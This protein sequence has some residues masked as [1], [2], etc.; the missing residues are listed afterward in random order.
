MDCAH[1]DE[2]IKIE[3]TYWWHIA[4]QELLLKLLQRFCRP[5]ARIVEGGIGGGNTLHTLS[6]LGYQVSGLDIIPEAIEHCRKIGISDVQV[7]NL[8]QP[9]PLEQGTYDAAVL[10]DVIE[11]CDDASAALRNARD[12]LKPEGK[13]IV[14]VPAYQFLMG[15]WD[16][17]LGHKRRYT[18]GM[19]RD[20]AGA[21]GL[22]VEWLSYWNSFSLPP[23]VVVRT[24]ERL[25]VADRGSEFPRVPDAINKTFIALSAAERAIMDKVSLPAGLSIMGVLSRA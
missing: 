24:F 17:K 8:E 18:S 2:L 11:H 20:H 23:A 7:A 3:Q 21:A 6:Q 15:P 12:V 25:C 14:S 22:K 4:K 19:L 13:V 5:P 16:L 10:L 1:L 9:W